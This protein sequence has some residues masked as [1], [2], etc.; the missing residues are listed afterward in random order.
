MQSPTLSA[1]RILRYC[2]ACPSMQSPTSI[3][4][5]NPAVLCRMPQY[6]A[7]YFDQHEESRG[8]VSHAPVCSH[9]LRS[10]RRILRYCV[11]CPS[12]QSP[13]L[14]AQSQKDYR[15]ENAFSFY[16]MSYPSYIL[17]PSLLLSISMIQISFSNFNFIS[18]LH[19]N[20][21]SKKVI[22]LMR[23]SSKQISKNQTDV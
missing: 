14:S 2:V 15:K 19:F 10:A 5:K 3:S 23:Q 8:I 21:M 11:A 12:M 9:L 6:E 22:A 17:Y 13:T 1:R 7:T 20:N 16:W 18:I 4:T